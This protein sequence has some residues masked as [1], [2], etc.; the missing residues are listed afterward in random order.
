MRESDWQDKGCQNE[1]SSAAAHGSSCAQST[2]YTCHKALYPYSGNRFT[3]NSKH[4]Y[5]SN[6]RD[7]NLSNGAGGVYKDFENDIDAS[8]FWGCS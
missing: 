6:Y 2:F 7:P 5:S 3:L 4:F 8:R 1:A